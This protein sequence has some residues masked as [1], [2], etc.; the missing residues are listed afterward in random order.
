MVSK[1][2]FH[3][4]QVG[5]EGIEPS[6]FAMWMQRS[7]I[8]LVAQ[9]LYDTM[10]RYLNQKSAGERIFDLIS[11]YPFY[12]STFHED[13]QEYRAEIYHTCQGDI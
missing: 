9:Y 7:T 6:A 4:L 8:E 1:G 11:I 5:D 3:V 2:Q 10:R 13:T 12:L